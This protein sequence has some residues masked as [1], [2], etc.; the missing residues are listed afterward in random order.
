MKTTPKEFGL[1]INIQD[2]LTART[3]EWERLEFKAGWNPE[4]V[5]HTMCA[6][7]NDLHNL[8][9]GYILIGVAEQKGQPVLP[10]AGLNP[11]ELDAIQKEVLRLGHLI[12]PPYHPLMAPCDVGGRVVLVLSA[13]GGQTRPYKAPVSLSRENREY[14]YYVRKGSATV[15]AK[16][17]DEVELISMAATVPFDDRINLQ[18]SLDDL[19]LGLVRAYLKRV[20]SDLYRSS[21]KMDFNDLCRRMNVAE[22][23]EERAHPKNV[24][25]MFFSERPEEFFPYCR[26]E[27]A[28]FPEG[29]GADS[30]TEKT[31]AGPLD[32]MLSEAINHL[33]SQ[34]VEEKV[35][36]HPDRAEAERCSN[37]PFVALEEALGNAVYHRA[38][39]VREPVEIRIL[40]DRILIHSV[41]GPDR[42]I[43]DVDLRNR[44][45]LPRRYRNRRIG[46]FLKELEL[47]EGRGDRHPENDTG[48]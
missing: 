37:Y 25:L 5:L 35:I 18:A 4:A 16:H 39:D 14:G 48:P 9:G 19:D 41:P 17:G 33:R 42:S 45:F 3:V 38:Y 21:A 7:A 22:G 31:F 43:R 47:T 2:L 8:G 23:P 13:P 34:V 11:K 40:P 20:G 36:K 27:V 24:G 12:I 46:E 44:R 29:L 30:F 28:H 32:R 1:P 15:R 26:I 6:F 10:A